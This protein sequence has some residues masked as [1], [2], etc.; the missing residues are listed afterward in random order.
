MKCSCCG[1]DHVC[2]VREVAAG[3]GAVGRLPELLAKYG[4]KKPF[5]FCDPNTYRA[6]GARVLEILRESGIDYRS[7]VMAEVRPKPDEHSVGSVAMHFDTSCDAIVAVGSGVLNDIGKILAN[8]TKKLYIT[9]ATAPSMDGYASNSSSMERD[10]LKVSLYDQSPDILI[11]DDEILAAAPTRMALSGLGDMLAKYVSICEWRIS[12]L[13]NGEYYC[14]QIADMMRS[15]LR[16][17]VEHADRLLARD[18]EAVGEVFSGLVQAGVAMQYAGVSRPASG[19]EHYFSHIWDMR[20]LAFGTP[21]DLHGIQCAVGT[22][23]TVRMYEK[24]LT[25][26]PD[27]E[28]ARRFAEAFDYPAWAEKLKCLVGPAADTM[29]ALEKKEGKYDV[30]KHHARLERILSHWEE[31]K[32][33]IREEL[34]SSLDLE[35]LYR[36]IGLPTSAAEIGIDTADL[37]TVFYATKDI[38]DKYVLSHLAYDLGVSEELAEVLS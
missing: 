9:V 5:V 20:A 3:R 14:E 26:T 27:R 19:V 12:H 33:V 38:R 36:K 23:Y 37:K 34:P 4:A 25:I 32:A 24:L 17:C 18:P 10:G 2:T 22:L 1:R 6:A 28:K 29:I 7:Y 15:A 13:V 21:A 30:A 31:I 11:G 16:S 8:L 35:A